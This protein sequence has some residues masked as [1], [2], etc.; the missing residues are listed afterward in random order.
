MKKPFF[1]RSL[2]VAFLALLLFAFSPFDGPSLDWV[3]RACAA[4]AEIDPCS[5]ENLKETHENSF[6]FKFREAQIN[7]I[8]AENL[9][10]QK[11]F[12]QDW[13]NSQESD[14]MN[15]LGDFTKRYCLE[16]Y[17]KVTEALQMLWQYSSHFGWIWALL[18]PIKNYFIDH[19]CQ[20]VV[21][22]VDGT[23]NK[24]C[25]PLPSM[26]LQFP[27]LELPPHT[28]CGGLSLDDI[29]QLPIPTPLVPTMSSPV[30]SGPI[31]R[32]AE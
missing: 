13:K 4:P 8:T 23:L 31:W 1:V 19:L 22:F 5:D 11:R 2:N 25:I 18:G 27:S 12:D 17:E 14:N 6:R 26:H 15:I 21:G 28:Y 7:R 10:A 20:Y 24:I 16:L 30:Y 32:S 3:G 9:A 29:D